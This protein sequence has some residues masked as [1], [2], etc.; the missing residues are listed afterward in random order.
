M[1]GRAYGG[2]LLKLEPREADQLPMPAPAT[3]AALGPALT[4]LRP[5]LTTALRRNHLERA[6]ALVDE[7][8]LSQHLNITGQDLTALRHA[9]DLLF[10]RRIS[11]G[12]AMATPPI[13]SAP[14]GNT[15]DDDGSHG[16]N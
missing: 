6:V 13:E 9:R 12:R 11:R 10:R 14:A 5:Q 4:A 8:M 15:A 16:E 1:V 7:V 3:V 2:G